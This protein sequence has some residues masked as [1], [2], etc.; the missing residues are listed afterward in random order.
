MHDDDCS[1]YSTF[2][3][4]YCEGCQRRWLIAV[5]FRYTYMDAV[6]QS[7]HVTG[8]WRTSH[9]QRFVHV[10]VEMVSAEVFR[11]RGALHHFSRRRRRQVRPRCLGE[12]GGGQGCY[13]G[14]RVAARAGE[15]KQPFTR[16]ETRRIATH[17]EEHDQVSFVVK[18]LGVRV[19]VQILRGVQF[20]I[21]GMSQQSTSRAGGPVGPL[22]FQMQADSRMHGSFTAAVT[23]RT[24]CCQCQRTLLSTLNH[25]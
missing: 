17:H 19:N 12:G 5:S 20:Q 8:R 3:S 11:G 1:C 7:C 25:N 14:V 4:F 6:T 23:I 9:G 15:Q 21:Q 13:A 18:S 2:R 16:F 10:P 22:F 24:G